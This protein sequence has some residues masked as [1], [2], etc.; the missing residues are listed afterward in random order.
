MKSKTLSVQNIT[1]I[2]VLAGLSVVLMLF[3]IPL[4][5]APPFLKF[6]FAE[7]PALLGS[8]AMGP[9]AGFAIVAVK[10]LLNL[11]VDG[12]TTAFVGELSNLVVNGTFIVTAGWYYKRN[13]TFKGAIQSMIIAVLA[14][15]LVATLSNYFVMFPLYARLYMPMD[16]ILKL[17]S[18]VNPWVHD[19]FTL[20]VFTVVPFNIVQGTITSIVTTLIYPRVSHLLKLKD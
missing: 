14:M 6:D 3:E 4:F 2:G 19:Y 8:Y 16:Q 12:T 20:M 13:R 10:V 9:G 5:F 7:V 18:S 1:R 11:V 17:S 15:T